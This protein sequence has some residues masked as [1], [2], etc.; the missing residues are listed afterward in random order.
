LHDQPDEKVHLTALK[1]I[2]GFLNARAAQGA[3]SYVHPIWKTN[4]DSA[5]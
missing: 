2:A 5:F 1:T 3:I 4:M